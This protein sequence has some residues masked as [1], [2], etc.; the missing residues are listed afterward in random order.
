M[1]E[2][3][4]ERL[5]IPYAPSIDSG[6]RIILPEEKI[7][8]IRQLATEIANAKVTEAHHRIDGGNEFK[9]QFTGLLGEASLEEFLGIDIVDYS[10][11]DSNNY[12]V[13][14]LNRSGLDIGVK[15]VED[16]KFPIVHKNP[17]RPEL[18]C[19]KRDNNEVLFFGYASVDTLRKYQTD[20]F[21]LDRRLR[22]RGTKASFYG[23]SE[24][25]PINSFEEL[26]SVYNKEMYK[27]Y[28]KIV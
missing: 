24:L 9:R 5:V 16:W 13:A 26:Q 17:I 22:Q 28:N 3:E 18:I 14:D 2:A 4:F 25:I 19:I 27:T 23:F 7:D 15:T 12:D 8:R 21:I 1:F 10:I 20:E 11:G 6:R